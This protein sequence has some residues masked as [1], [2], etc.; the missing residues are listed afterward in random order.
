M[1]YKIQRIP[2]YFESD[3]PIPKPKKGSERKPD[4]FRYQWPWKDMQSGDSFLLPKGATLT[5]AKAAFSALKR[6]KSIPDNATVVSRKLDN[7][8][9]RLWRIDIDKTERASE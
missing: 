8:D 7:G 2:V 4:D 5:V 6:R 3:I 1:S 9:I